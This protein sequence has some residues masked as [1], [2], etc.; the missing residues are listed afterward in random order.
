MNGHDTDGRPARRAVITGASSGIGAALA[1]ELS[2]R[3][4]QVALLA[5]RLEL[6]REVESSLSTR[7][8]SVACDVGDAGSVRNAVRLAEDALGGPFDLAVANAGVGLPTVGS[9]FNLPDAELMVR[10]NVL[11]MLYLFDAVVPSMVERRSGRFVG[12]ASIAGHRGLPSASVYSATKSFMHTF[13]EASRIELKAH[14]VGVTTVN[15]GFIATAMTEKNRFPMPFLMNAGEAA[16]IIA[17]GIDRGDREIEFPLP[18]GLFMRLVRLVPNAWFE[19]ASS[20]FARRK[21]NTEKL[22]R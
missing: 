1:V 22:R 17:D 20:G 2:R 4:W 13:L 8:F 21:V 14:G 11:G 7:G 19:M 15:P 10:V 16:T 6:L 12:V 18:M 3:G 9:T 5:R